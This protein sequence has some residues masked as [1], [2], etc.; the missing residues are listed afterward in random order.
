MNG[1]AEGYTRTKIKLYS[2]PG[3]PALVP[4]TGN[5]PTPSLMW[6][7]KRLSSPAKTNQRATE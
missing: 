6:S 5:G 2:L 1:M 7:G 3:K 4:Q